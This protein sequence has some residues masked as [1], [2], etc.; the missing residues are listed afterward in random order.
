MLNLL[1]DADQC[2]V[3]IGNARIQGL[4]KDLGMHGT[5]YN[6]ALFVVFIPFVL[7]E[8]PSN[9]ILKL[10]SPKVWL[11][12]LL[13]GCGKFY[14]AWSFYWLGLTTTGLMSICQGVVKS[15]EGLVACR[16]VLGIFEAG[17]SPG[18]ILLIS[19]YYR[20]EELPW[21]L[22]WWYM[23]GTAAGAFGGLLAYAIANMNGVAGYS[24]WRW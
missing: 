2:S 16:F 3:N 14:L 7:C 24:G 1:A 20:R 21:R 17:L 19:M 15:Y 9:L 6:V 12:F 10:V 23:S 8:T 4:E 22:S 11:S 5:N 13:F 18:T